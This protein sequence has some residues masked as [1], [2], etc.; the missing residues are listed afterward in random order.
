MPS[1]LGSLLTVGV[2]GSNIGVTDSVFEKSPSCSPRLRS[3]FRVVDGFDMYSIKT[4]TVLS[5]TF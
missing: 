5:A 3:H 2:L 4:S 1:N